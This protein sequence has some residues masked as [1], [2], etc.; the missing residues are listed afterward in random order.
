[1]RLRIR[2]KTVIGEREDAVANG[3]GPM[4]SGDRVEKGRERERE[5]EREQRGRVA[6][7]GRRS[8]T[9]R[10]SREGK[11]QAARSSENDS[12]RSHI[13]LL[14][15]DIPNPVPPGT[16]GDF[17]PPSFFPPF[18]DPQRAAAEAAAES[19]VSLVP[20]APSARLLRLAASLCSPL[21]RPWY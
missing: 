3:S 5:R 18:H 11:K 12:I 17:F 14:P 9:R 1:M 13:N 6:K 7:E 19:G 21:P 20:L 8:R 2:E 15:A 10:E 16:N 4:R